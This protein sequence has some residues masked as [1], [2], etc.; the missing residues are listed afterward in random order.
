MGRIQFF[1]KQRKVKMPQVSALMPVYNSNLAY[2][3]E[4][5]E[6]VLNQSFSDFEF[7]ILNDSPENAELEN[8]ILNYAQ[9]DSRIKYHKNP[10]NLGISLSRNRLIKLA[11]G[12]F[13]AVID[14][15]DI[16]V[17]ERFEKQ[18]NFLQANAEVGVVGGF[19]K[20]IS[21]GKILSFPT[22]DLEIRLSLMFVA[23]MFHPTT[24]IRASILH[25]A[26]AHYNELYSFGEDSKLWLDLLNSTKF[27]NLPEPLIFY[28]NFENTTQ[29]SQVA[30]KAI[31]AALRHYNETH[32]SELFALA[33]ERCVKIKRVRILGISVLKIIECFDKKDFLL[34][35]KIK[36]CSIRN[37]RKIQF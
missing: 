2:L 21:N 17:K 19:A 27:A 9:K 5:I 3:K 10:R 20:L 30:L 32:H 33:N 36:I 7:L 18:I 24:M 13:L 28:R 15:D 34:F 1:I 16:S 8:F 26:N 29:K 22:K 12:E 6:S 14:H 37:D 11:Q 23:G 25:A 35:S 31:W 4:T